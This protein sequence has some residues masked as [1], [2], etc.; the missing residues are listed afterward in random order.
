MPYAPTKPTPFL[1]ALCVFCGQSS[2]FRNSRTFTTAHTAPHPTSLKPR[3]IGLEALNLD[4]VTMHSGLSS[5]V[6]CLHLQ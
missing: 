2:Y 4:L 3:V 6:T 5:I 1:C